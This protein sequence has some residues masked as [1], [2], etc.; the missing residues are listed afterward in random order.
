MRIYTMTGFVDGVSRRDDR[1]YALLSVDP[2]CM[3]FD[4]EE[5]LCLST[6]DALRPLLGEDAASIVAASGSAVIVFEDLASAAAV[7][8][9]LERALPTVGDIGLVCQ[10]RVRGHVMIDVRQKG[11]VDPEMPLAP[12]HELM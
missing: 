12:R 7:A 6:L 11:V 5:D 10:V 1:A 3:D 4:D 8:H 2:G 9:D